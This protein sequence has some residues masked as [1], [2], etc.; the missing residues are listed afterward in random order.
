MQCARRRQ[1]PGTKDCQKIRAMEENK[2][3]KHWL[4]T[5]FRCC[6]TEAATSFATVAEAISPLAQNLDHGSC[7]DPFATFGTA[8]GA[9][10]TASCPDPA[11]TPRSRQ[12]CRLRAKNKKTHQQDPV[13]CGRRILRLRP[14]CSH[15]RK[16]LWRLQRLPPLPQQR[17]VA[18]EVCAHVWARQVEACWRR[19]RQASRSSVPFS[20]RASGPPPWR[21]PGV[22]MARLGNPS[23]SLPIQ[24]HQ[25]SVRKEKFSSHELIE[26]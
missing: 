23:P 18:R 22:F 5:C 10:T 17:V 15:P 6:A 20:P 13:P 14:Q 24:Q 1:P 8:T 3:Q 2:L 7:E 19:R 11:P 9:G 12:K 4:V 21:T 16:Y 26:M 25:H